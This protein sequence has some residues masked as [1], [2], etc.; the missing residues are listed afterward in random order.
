[1][2]TP[3]PAKPTAGSEPDADR[4]ASEATYRKYLADAAKTVT[5]ATPPAD[6]HEEPG[7]YTDE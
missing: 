4:A 6:M 3:D 1:M 7:D 5:F 2:I